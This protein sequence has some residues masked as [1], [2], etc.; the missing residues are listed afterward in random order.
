M[1]FSFEHDLV[2]CILL[3]NYTFCGLCNDVH[4]TC[5]L[6]LFILSEIV[7]RIESVFDKLH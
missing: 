3:V 7:A 5:G 6:S 1:C 2:C 4:V